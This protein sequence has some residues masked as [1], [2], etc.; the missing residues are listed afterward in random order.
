[1]LKLLVVLS[2]LSL[3]LSHELNLISDFEGELDRG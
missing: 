2:D 1:M 3:F